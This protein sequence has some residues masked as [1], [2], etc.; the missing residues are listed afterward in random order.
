[1]TEFTDLFESTGKSLLNRTERESINSEIRVLP[2]PLQ[3]ASSASAQA[4]ARTAR[5][6]SLYR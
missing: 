5:M 3:I 6:R 1:M 2:Y 4:V